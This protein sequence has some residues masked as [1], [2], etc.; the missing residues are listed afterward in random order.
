MLSPLEYNLSISHERKFIWFRVAKVATRTIFSHFATHAVR[1]DVDHAMRMRYPT[2]SFEDYYKFAFVRDPLDR[3]TS[4]WRNKVVNRNYFGFDEETHARM[5]RVEH[6][7]DWAAQRDLADL[8]VT[9]HHLALQSRLIDL[10]NID[11]LGRLEHFDRDFATVCEH[12]GA[13]VSPPEAR[14]QTRSEAS[15]HELPSAEL[16]S[17]ITEMYRLDYQIFGY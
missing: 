15:E 11:F 8:A 7:A 1:L 9:D 2:A 13:P 5:Q 4:A 3:F 16:R 17:R 10:T 14:N 6:F 12:I